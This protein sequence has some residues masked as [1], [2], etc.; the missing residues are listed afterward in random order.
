MAGCPPRHGLGRPLCGGPFGTRGARAGTVPGR[1]RSVPVSAI[2]KEPLDRDQIVE[3]S[4]L[5][6]FAL[7]FGMQDKKWRL[8]HKSKN[9]RHEIRIVILA[10]NY[11]NQD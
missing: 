1:R 6:D 8:F 9:S 11:E 10:A 5:L 4:A 2:V 7:P 3:I